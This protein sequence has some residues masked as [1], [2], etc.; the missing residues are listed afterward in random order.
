MPECEPQ[1][2]GL[3]QHLQCT[4]CLP[5]HYCWCI[6][7]NIGLHK[8][9]F[10]NS[11]SNMIR[12]HADCVQNHKYSVFTQQ[13]QKLILSNI[14]CNNSILLSLLLT[15]KMICSKQGSH[16]FCTDYSSRGGGHCTLQKKMA[17]NMFS[18][19]VNYE[20]CLFIYDWAKLVLICTQPVIR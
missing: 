9:L 16:V 2:K 6:G 12:F 1:I 14:F 11:V 20:I 4:H 19:T 3:V 17:Q 15:L 10:G 7:L 8:F 5:Q 13:M 18:C